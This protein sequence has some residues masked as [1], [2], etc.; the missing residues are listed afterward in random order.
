MYMS[1][2]K[3]PET[4]IYWARDNLLGNFGICTVMTR[5]QFDKISQ[6]F[7]NNDRISIPLNARGKEID[8]LYLIRCVLDIGQN[9]IQ[10]NYIPCQN[11]SVDEAMIAF[12]GHL[13]L[14]QYLPAKPTKLVHEVC[15]SHNGYSFNFDVYL[16]CPTGPGVMK[17]AKSSWAKKLF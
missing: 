2:V 3:L 4:R 17:P 7:H 5:D 13:R 11:V 14:R 1:I 15:D 16:G 10:N 12:R 9:Q 8:K 6:Y